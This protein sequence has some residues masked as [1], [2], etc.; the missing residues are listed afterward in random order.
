MDYGST[1]LWDDAFQFH[2]DFGWYFPGDY[3]KFS[4]SSV[5]NSVSTVFST[6][7]K[8]GVVF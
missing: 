2:L 5:E 6:V 8:I 4:N 1:F 3:Y 7:F